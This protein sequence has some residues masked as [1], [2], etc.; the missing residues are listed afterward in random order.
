MNDAVANINE[1]GARHRRAQSIAKCNAAMASLKKTTTQLEKLKAIKADRSLTAEQ[2]VAKALK[3]GI[4]PSSIEKLV[5][6][7]ALEK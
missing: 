2:K 7:Q 4:A 6:S 1:I 5:K 3:L